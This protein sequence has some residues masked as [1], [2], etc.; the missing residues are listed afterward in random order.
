MCPEKGVSHEFRVTVTESDE[1]LGDIALEG[2]PSL[3]ISP[4][5]VFGGQVDCYAPQELFVSSIAAC[6]MS[7]FLGILRKMKQSIDSLDIEGLGVIEPNP[8]GGWHF[9]EIVVKLNIRASGE[10]AI[11]KISRAVQLTNKYCMVARAVSSPIR[12]ELVL[13]GKTTPFLEEQM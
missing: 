7:T 3:P 11:T 1:R 10:D 2:R 13:N 6:T 8:E 12:L 4:P 5:K 9:T